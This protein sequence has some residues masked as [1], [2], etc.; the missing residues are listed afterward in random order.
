[1]NGTSIGRRVTVDANR[2]G[3][4]AA[5]GL[6]WRIVAS[7]DFNGDGKPDIVWHNDTTNE[8]QIWFMDGASRVGRATVRAENGGSIAVGTPW[9]IVGANDFDGDGKSDILWHNAVTGETQI[10]LMN[11][12]TIASRVSVD[13]A[14]DGG[15]ALV[16]AP[17]SIVNH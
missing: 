16:G 17:W 7:G 3:G 5:V 10:W 13:A 2:D 8:T 1:M 9:A 14:R 12:F 11:G 15:G 4:G 6:P